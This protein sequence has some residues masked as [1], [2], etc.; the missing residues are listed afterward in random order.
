MT[1]LTSYNMKDKVAF[2]TGAANG[3]GRAA[4]MAFAQNGAHVMA[5]D[6]NTDAGTLTVA[7]IQEAGGSAHFLKCDVSNS[8]DV[9]YAV[10][11]TVSIYGQLNYAFNNAGI[12]GAQAMTPDCSE[13]NWDKVIS[14]NLKGVW[15]CM[16]YQI[17]HMLKQ[18]GGTIVNCSS[19]AGIVGFSGITAYV[20]S[21]H[22][23][24][25]LTK[26]AALEYAKNNIRV[27]AI[28]PGVIQTPMIER[29]THGEAQLRSQLVS[30]EPIGRIGQPEEVAAATLWLCS[31]QSSFITGHPL[32]IDGGWIAQ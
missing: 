20:A 28:C 22:G 14:V 7:K 26:T 30:G 3:I 25:G 18:G 12:E 19:I 8:A 6:T 5:I 2:I 23:V 31:D 10:T 1:P 32:V 29:F 27:N 21:K 16:K 17:P 9:K 15:L 11:K 4:A 13:E 24:I